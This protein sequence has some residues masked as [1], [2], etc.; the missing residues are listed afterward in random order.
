MNERW[1]LEFNVK[2]FME[3]IRGE[4]RV[5]SLRDLEKIFGVSASTFSRMDN[6]EVPNMEVLIKI[7]SRLHMRPDNYFVFVKWVKDVPS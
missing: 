2:S 3:D 5:S 6:G 4:T 7:C 1:E